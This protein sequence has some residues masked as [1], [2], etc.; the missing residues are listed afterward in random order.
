[1]SDTPTRAGFT[2]VIGAPNAGKSTLVNRLVGAKVTI[3]TRKVQTTRFPVRGVAM[4]G[5]SQ[6]VLVDTPGVF[7]PKGRLDR[8]MVR[9]VW[10]GV[11]EAGEVTRRAL[12]RPPAPVEEGSNNW[13]IGP[14]RSAALPDVPT[15]GESGVPGFEAGLWFG[16]MAPAGTSPAIIDRMQKE[17][18][19]AVASQQVIDT[20]AAT[21]VR[22]IAT[23]PATFTKMVHSETMLWAEVNT[24]AKTAPQ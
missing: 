7:K 14:Q 16:M 6:I 17:I 21:G 4:E 9:S 13:A 2:A 11:D 24:R 18:T 22:A 12:S 3:V 1:M 5:T 23:S 20:F 19:K 15:F 8:A 10:T